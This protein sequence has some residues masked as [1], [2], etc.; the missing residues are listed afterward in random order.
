MTDNTPPGASNLIDAPYNDDEISCPE[1][2]EGVDRDNYECIYCDGKG[3]I[4]EYEYKMVKSLERDE[5]D[6]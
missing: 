2:D 5:S 4:S 6:L 3:V 1:C